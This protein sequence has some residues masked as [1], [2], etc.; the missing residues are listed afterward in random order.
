MVHRDKVTTI[1]NK[2]QKRGRQ[3]KQIANLLGNCISEFRPSSADAI[4]NSETQVWLGKCGRPIARSDYVAPSLRTYSTGHASATRPWWPGEAQLN[5][6]AERVVSST[7]P[8]LEMTG[9][10]Q[11]R[12]QMTG[13]SEGMA[14]DLTF[15]LC[16]SDL[17]RTIIRSVCWRAVRRPA[18]G[19]MLS[20]SSLRRAIQRICGRAVGAKQGRD[21]RRN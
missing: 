11:V 20:G 13:C 12:F 2:Q 14:N 7:R 15:D 19:F 4:A 10:P 8:A 16:F 6:Y 21:R 18:S 1:E 5:A 17:S 3:R 9:T